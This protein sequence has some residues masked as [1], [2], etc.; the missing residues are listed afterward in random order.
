MQ[1]ASVP[2]A[3]RAITE[4]Q[5][6]SLSADFEGLNLTRYIQEAVSCGSV[7]CGWSLL[8]VDTAAAEKASLYA[9]HSRCLQLHGTYVR[10]PTSP[11]SLVAR[12]CGCV[13]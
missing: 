10:T 3:Q 1:S 6:D 13:S 11:V 12:L 2:C 7:F 4:Q 5:R 9:D 8:V